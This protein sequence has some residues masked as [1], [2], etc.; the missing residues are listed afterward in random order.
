MFVQSIPLRNG[1]KSSAVGAGGGSG[2]RARGLWFQSV[3]GPSP[4]RRGRLEILREEFEL[5]LQYRDALNS[6]FRL[7]AIALLPGPWWISF[8]FLE[9]GCS[10]RSWRHPRGQYL[11]V[12]AILP[13]AMTPLL[14]GFRCF[15]SHIPIQLPI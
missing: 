2:K 9:R 4:W 6:A 8:G 7:W 12:A 13:L 5:A 11:P 15:I 3:P 14:G 10:Q 1:D